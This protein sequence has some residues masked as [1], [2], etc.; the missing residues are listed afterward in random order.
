MFATLLATVISHP[1]SHNVLADQ[2]TLAGLSVVFIQWLKNRSWFPWIT[3]H[4]DQ[5]NRY[6]SAFLAAVVAVGITWTWNP[7][8]H[9]LTISNLSLSMIVPA[10]YAWVKQFVFNELTYR[11]AAKRNGNG[12]PAT[13]TTK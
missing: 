6:L 11:V 13:A 8:A 12:A 10:G 3:A 4:T 9:S 2:I 5:A 7:E 1:G